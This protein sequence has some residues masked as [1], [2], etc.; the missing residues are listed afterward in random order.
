MAGRCCLCCHAQSLHWG[1]HRREWLRVSGCTLGAPAI[2]NSKHSQWQSL[3]V[4]EGVAPLTVHCHLRWPWGHWLGHGDPASVQQCSHR[5]LQGF[6]NQ[7]I[8]RGDGFAGRHLA[9]TLWTA[10]GV[11]GSQAQGS[12]SGGTAVHGSSGQRRC[13]CRHRECHRHCH[14]HLYHRRRPWLQTSSRPAREERPRTE[15]TTSVDRPP[16]GRRCGCGCGCYHRRHHCQRQRWWHWRWHH[17]HATLERASLD[18][19]SH[20]RHR[21]PRSGT[22]SGPAG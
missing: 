6:G 17:R 14:H 15:G 18:S 7:G 1:Q 11:P 13:P 22:R 3:Q 9:A 20:H 16:S 2:A 19:V 10:H 5:H 12:A 8:H 4:A 21:L